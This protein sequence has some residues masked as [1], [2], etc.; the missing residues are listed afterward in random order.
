MWST[1]LNILAIIGVVV[2]GAIIVY[3]VAHLIITGLGK[4][5]KTENKVKDKGSKE[6]TVRPTVLETNELDNELVNEQNNQQSISWNEQKAAEEKTKIDYNVNN[7]QSQT[8]EDNKK[9]EANFDGFDEIFSDSNEPAVNE[10]SDKELE[11]IIEKVNTESV[12]EYNALYKKEE[13]P[14]VAE[15]PKQEIKKEEAKQE[16]DSVLIEGQTNLFDELDKSEEEDI[17]YEKEREEL[18]Q[19]R[20]ELEEEQAKIEEQ[21]ANLEEQRKQLEEEMKRLEELKEEQAN[22]VVVSDM[23][24]IYSNESLEQ[25]EARLEM[26]NERLKANKKDL[27]ENKKEYNPLA[28]VKK[29]LEKD[30]AKLTRREAIVAR[31]KVI[32]YG[33][34]NYVDIDEEKAKKL[35]E[36]LDLLDGLRLSVQHCEDVMNANKD[37]FPILEKTNKILKKVNAEILADIA[38]VEKAIEEKKKQEGK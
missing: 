12:A 6:K 32:L 1:F 5:S 26:L 18:E 33:V 28:R 36:D 10:V 27:R 22:S 37:R 30:K 14:V 11:K 23:S 15:K 9:T 7:L 13:K 35:N 20:K 38:E 2:V 29:T 3:L 16:E 17:N 24:S 21:K 19:G 25:L 8:I 34:N 4:D 31:Q